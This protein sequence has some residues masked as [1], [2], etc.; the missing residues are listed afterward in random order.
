MEDTSGM[1]MNCGKLQNMN[2]LESPDNLRSA[3]AMFANCTN[4]TET[5]YFGIFSMNSLLMPYGYHEGTNIFG[6]TVSDG[7]PYLT[8]EGAQ[9]MFYGVTDVEPNSSGELHDRV[10]DHVIEQQQY[11][12]ADEDNPFLEEHPE[13]AAKVDQEELSAVRRFSRYKREQAVAQGDVKTNM[14]VRTDGGLTGNVIWNSKTQKYEL[15]ETGYVMGDQKKGGNDL[16]NLIASGGAGLITYGLSGLFT[17]SKLVRWGLGIGAGILSYKSGILRNSLS[18]LLKGIEKMLPEGPVKDVVHKWVDDTDITSHVDEQRSALQSEAIAADQVGRISDVSGTALRS[19]SVQTDGIELYMNNN[20]A[21]MGA[22][23]CGN[24]RGACVFSEVAKMGENCEEFTSTKEASETTMSAME[25]SWQARLDAG[26]DPEAVYGDMAGYYQRIF[27][28]MAA[29]NEG[30]NNAMNRDFATD[31]TTLALG[32]AGLE[33]T[34]RATMEPVLDSMYRM[35]EKYHIF[36]PEDMAQLDTYPISGIGKVSE[37][38]PGC[39]EL[40]RTDTMSNVSLAQDLEMYGVEDTDWS[41]TEPENAGTTVEQQ[42]DSTPTSQTPNPVLVQSPAEQQAEQGVQQEEAPT[43]TEEKPNTS[44][45]GR[46]LPDIS[47]ILV[48]R[49]QNVSQ[50]GA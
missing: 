4:I 34:N 49:K 24:G 22:R 39:L 6:A 15:D 45:R 16:W 42:P 9:D 43:T 44:G 14:E 41:T 23:M 50:F 19:A 11:L 28:G 5:N 21:M 38:T 10:D 46:D 18:P 32:Q 40:Y 33:M 25:Q 3:N 8:T 12:V 27:S 37:Y 48:P 47:G 26:E 13:T 1:F 36:T 31:S 20:G 30:A 29:Y 17:K 7:S 35:N 2:F